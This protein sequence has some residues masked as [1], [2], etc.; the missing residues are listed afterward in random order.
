M[1]RATDTPSAGN[2]ETRR[3]LARRRRFGQDGGRNVIRFTG[4]M[5]YIETRAFCLAMNDCGGRFGSTLDSGDRYL[6]LEMPTVSSSRSSLLRL[7]HSFERRRIGKPYRVSVRLYR[8]ISPVGRHGAPPVLISNST[9]DAVGPR[10]FVVGHGPRTDLS[11]PADLLPRHLALLCMPQAD[12]VRMRLLVL[13]PERSFSIPCGEDEKDHW[14]SDELSD[15]ERYGGLESSSPLRVEFERL[16]LEVD[17]RYP[18]QTQLPAEA[19]TIYFRPGEQLA[20]CTSNHTR[21]LNSEVGSVVASVAGPQGGGH[22]IPALTLS[23]AEGAPI[24]G[25]LSLRTRDGL[26]RADAGLVDLRRGLLIGRSR[27]CVLGRTFHEND[28]LSRLHALV[29]SFDDHV[30]AFDLASRYGLRDVGRPTQLI[31]TARLDDGVGCLVYG[32]GHLI[33]ES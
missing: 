26:C 29:T 15:R 10:V 13:H 2:S 18:G 23:S 9:F 7:V 6:G 27:R 3:Q 24:S 17:G 20:F 5:G 32:A 33:F 21:S 25:V 12:H 28:G 14:P 31:H 1:K 22:A 4:C 11:G 16:L 30:Y 19:T 8:R